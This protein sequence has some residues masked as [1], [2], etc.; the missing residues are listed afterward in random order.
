MIIETVY[1]PTYAPIYVY[2]Y[3]QTS[4]L[5]YGGIGYAATRLQPT[6]VHLRTFVQIL[7]IAVVQLRCLRHLFSQRQEA[8]VVRLLSDIYS[9]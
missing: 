7:N 1:I 6:I 2:T 5:P 4:I 3:V 8:L 9:I